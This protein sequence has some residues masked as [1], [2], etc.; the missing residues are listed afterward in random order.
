MTRLRLGLGFLA[1]AVILLGISANQLGFLSPTAAETK[2]G[3]GD[4]VGYVALATSI[5]SLITGIVSLA[6]AILE[7]RKASKAGSQ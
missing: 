4:T 5:I 2:G 6:K 1:L 3:S 7:A